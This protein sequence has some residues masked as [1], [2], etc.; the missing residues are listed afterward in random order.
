VLFFLLSLLAAAGG[1]GRVLVVG[2]LVVFFSAALYFCFMTAWL[3]FFALLGIKRAVTL[4][5]GVGVCGIGIVNAKELVWFR[6]G[7]SLAIP[8]RAKPKIVE[9]MR[10]VASSRSAALTVAGTAAL[11]FLVNIAEFGCT[12]GLPAVY[13]RVL[14][15]RQTSSPQNYAYMALYCAAY[16]APLASVSAAFAFATVR[17]RLTEGRGRILKTV[18]GLVMLGLGLLLIF[19]PGYLSFS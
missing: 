12:V 18:S 17:I 9:R 2:G 5:L 16:A 8:D 15:L 4:A 11:A 13:T 14:T 3:N 7:P 10:K 1:R 6:K 19:R